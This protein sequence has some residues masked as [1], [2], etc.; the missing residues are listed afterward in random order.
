VENGALPYQILSLEYPKLKV[1]L[2]SRGSLDEMERALNNI[3]V[4]TVKEPGMTTLL[5]L[6]NFILRYC[7]YHR[8]TMPF[9]LHIFLSAFF[10][11]D[12]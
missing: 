11:V 7:A 2:F 1:T 5:W 9:Q 3:Q 10:P 6:S 8:I 4:R 12:F